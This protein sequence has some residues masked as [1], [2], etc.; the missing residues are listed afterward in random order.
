MAKT[1]LKLVPPTSELREVKVCKR[2]NEEM[3]RTREYLTKAEIERLVEAAK[4]KTEREKKY[5]LRNSTMILVGYRHGLRVS[6]LTDLQWSDVD[7]KASTLHIRRAKG[8]NTGSHPIRGD[9]LR[10]LRA[11]QAQQIKAGR[12][13]AWIFPTQRDTAFTTAAFASLISKAGERAKLPFKVHPHMLRHTMVY[14]G[15]NS[16]WG[17]REVQDYLGHKSINSTTRY[18]RLAHERFKNL[19]EKL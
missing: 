11:L 6:E 17:L 8:G 19:T 18:A 4:G 5:A 7:F 10:A 16:G 3:G 13:C 2:S 12:Q 9:E 14:V 15:I 1:N